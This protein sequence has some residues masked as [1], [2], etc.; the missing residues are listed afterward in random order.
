MGDGRG[1]RRASRGRAGPPARRDSPKR[2]GRLR[3][4]RGARARSGRAASTASRERS[5]SSGSSRIAS[6]R[7]G[8]G[9]RNS[10]GWRRR[11]R[12]RRRPPP[13]R[14]GSVDG[15]RRSRRR[16]QRARWPT[17][18]A[19]SRSSS[20]TSPPSKGRT[21]PLRSSSSSGGCS[22]STRRK[23]TSSGWERRWSSRSAPSPRW[24]SDMEAI[25]TSS[26]PTRRA[27]PFRSTGATPASREAG[28]KRAPQ[29]LAAALPG[30]RRR[31][32]ARPAPSKGWQS[33][34]D[35]P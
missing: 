1:V 19:T 31:S 23:R 9:R 2:L 14:S 35:P 28:R 21:R 20:K 4:A 12:P 3:H 33:P 25:G 32:P 15:S 27:S 24:P 11:S 8:T 34:R 6:C 7:R 30:S 13:G 5:S 26:S 22:T 16:R 10:R 17:A 18:T 29:P